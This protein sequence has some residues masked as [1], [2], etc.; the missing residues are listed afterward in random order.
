MYTILLLI[1][2]FGSF[3]HIRENV[4]EVGAKREKA[5]KSTKNIQNY[6]LC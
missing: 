1:R 2:F 3:L 4:E 6:Y 5:E